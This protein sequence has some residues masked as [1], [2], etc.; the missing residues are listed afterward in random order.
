MRL[1]SYRLSAPQPLN[2]IM[3]LPLFVTQPERQSFLSTDKGDRPF[4]S[5]PLTARKALSIRPFGGFLPIVIHVQQRAHFTLPC[6]LFARQKSAHTYPFV[7]EPPTVFYSWQSDAD[8]NCNQRF[9]GECLDAAVKLATDKM[10]LPQG[11]VVR[12]DTTDG[13]GTPSIPAT[14]FRRIDECAVF[15]GDVTLV[16]GSCDSCAKDGIQKFPNGNVALELGYAVKT[17]GWNRI[18]LTM[19][20]AYGKPDEQIFHLL[21]HRNPVQF[22][23]KNDEKRVEVRKGLIKNL[24]EYIEMALGEEHDQANRIF[25][26]LD[27]KSLELLRLV[28]E[29]RFFSHQSK[30][31]ILL[32]LGGDAAAT[33]DAILGDAVIRL[34]DLGII[35][36][37]YD[38]AKSLYAYHW[39]YLGQ[40]IL[41][42]I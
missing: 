37:D 38:K 28:K 8:R 41:Q 20:T 10:T 19:N 9:I 14:I 29:E 21:Q 7:M 42:K 22:E 3:F 25:R 34:L 33:F 36:S 11:L 26:R 2:R 30:E 16:A 1:A 31:K 4:G 17:L 24:A 5:A 6:D 27:L 13:A 18:L 12:R 35:F 15:V 39:T 32:R 40:L 23:L